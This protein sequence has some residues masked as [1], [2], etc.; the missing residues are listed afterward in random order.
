MIGSEN[1]RL[2]TNENV[3][4]VLFSVVLKGLATN[5][6]LAA[7]DSQ[8]C[9]LFNGSSSSCQ[10]SDAMQQLNRDWVIPKNDLQGKKTAAAQAGLARAQGLPAR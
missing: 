1:I 3:S 4:L 8:L 9:R 10:L 2:H 7:W 6:E 5:R